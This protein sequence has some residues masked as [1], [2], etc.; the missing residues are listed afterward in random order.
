VALS[1]LRWTPALVALLLLAG[2]DTGVVAPAGQVGRAEYLI[3]MDSL[4]IMLAIVIPTILVTLFFAWWY[5][6][7]NT[8]A[9]YRPRWA[10]SGR[11]EL[12]IWSIPTLVILF[13]GG[14]IWTGSHQLDP[15]RPLVSSE[16][17]LDVQVVSLD[18]KW[19]FIYP[20][21][22]IATVNELVVPAGR[23]VHFSL[24]SASVMNSFF[25]PQLGG[26]IATMNRMV[27][28]LH[29]VADRPG[30]YYGQSTQFSGDGFADMNF[31]LRA[32]PPESFSEWVTAVREKGPVLN[33]AAYGSLVKQSRDVRPFTYRAADPAL[34]HAIVHQELPPGPGPSVGRAG[35]E[36]R[37]EGNY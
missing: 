14:L 11:L 4:A 29:L 5:R 13:L 33:R 23:P 31:V 9:L 16:K 12:I 37:P 15:A 1:P 18:W 28:Q 7:S 30:N 6:A 24:T 10:Y 21:Q 17:A 20:E 8:R 22:R 32:V 2:C 25:V 34:F 35:P 19:L 36:V 3:L 27:T 26:M